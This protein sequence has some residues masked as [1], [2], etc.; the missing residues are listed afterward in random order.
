M[1]RNDIDWQGGEVTFWDL[2]GLDASAPLASQLDELKEDLAQVRYGARLVLD[3]GWY[4]DGAPHGQF[5]VVVVKDRDWDQPVFRERA[6]TVPALRS[7]LQ[8]AIT[9]ARATER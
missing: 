1:N 3:V 4:P 9:A 2:D 7:A 6:P 5:S 8:R